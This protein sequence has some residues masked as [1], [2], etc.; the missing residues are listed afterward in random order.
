MANERFGIKKYSPDNQELELNELRA[1]MAYPQKDY[2]QNWSSYGSYGDNDDKIGFREVLRRIRKHKWLILTVVTILTTLV[3]IHMFRVKP[4]YTAST[5]LEIGKDNSMILKSGDLTLND[6]SDPNYLVNIN[7]KKL[8]LE[9]PDLYKKVVSEQKLD[10]NPKVVENLNKKPLLSFLKFSEPS[11][12]DS[13]AIITKMGM[14]DESIKLAPFVAY[15]QKNVVIEQIRNTRALRIS[16]TDEDPE[17]AANVTNTI[18]KLFM[19]RS[20]DTQ[21]E[22]FTNSAEWL[23]Q[24]TRELKAKV[25]SSEQALADYSRNNEIYS[26]GTGGE[27]SSPTLTTSKLTQLHDQFV[28]AQTERL[29]KKSLYE[30][31]EAGRVAELPEA[32][33]D[34]KI[35]Q[36][37]QQLASLQGQAAELKVKFGPTNPKVMEVQNQIDVL[38]SQ[39]ESSRNALVAKLKADYERA[40]KDEQSLAGALNTAKSFAVNEN[41]ASIKYNILKQ[42]AETARALYT[43]F[44][45]KTNQAKTQVAEQNNNIKVIQNAQIPSSP[46]GPNRL[47]A[48][49]AGFVLSLGAGIGLAFFLEYLDDTVKSAEDVERYMQLPAIGIIPKISKRSQG[50]FKRRNNLNQISAS[51][52]GSQL[53]LQVVH[54]DVQSDLLSNLDSHPV[55]REAYSALRTSLLLSTAG[56]AP[57]TI[58]ITSSQASE[59]KS[60]TA[61]N[62]AI[63][64]AKTGAKV[65]ILDCDLRR[66]TIHTHLGISSANGIT[67]YLTSDTEI[68]TVIQITA[69]PNL[70]VVTSGPIPPNPA[71]LLSSVKMKEMISMLGESFDHIVIDSPPI[72]NVTDPVILSTL[73]DG[74]II[75]IHAG[76]TKRGIAAR[77]H[78][79][80]SN[81]GARVFGVV[82]NN[83]DPRK[84][85]YDDYYGYSEYKLNKF[86][87]N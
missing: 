75:V 6:D 21:T 74:A 87:T 32:F 41:Q 58:L 84:H 49:L 22:K 37:Q 14:D 54:N 48:I 19:E 7:T 3:T 59:G 4:W 18:A 29:L 27:N 76:K 45:Q 47:S 68:D 31:V 82:L 5:V 79:E 15:I 36:F 73:V 57:K 78:Y 28:R 62:T 66:P 65:L 35:T 61:I 64:L 52:D 1:V 50:F 12:N 63:F 16:F 60:T 55:A 23:D 85:G 38:T 69:I 39:I 44:L 26:T 8:I 33:S 9:D 40:V 20:F 67:N 43:D 2:P 70:S 83:L 51:E 72:I 46:D 80:L 10:Q 77:S 13:D 86:T 53:G 71:E 81:V 11:K 25:Q 34:P 30:Q 56:N 17:L 42:D 24:S